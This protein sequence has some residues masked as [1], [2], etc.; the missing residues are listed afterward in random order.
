MLLLS[1]ISLTG[2]WSAKRGHFL[3]CAFDEN[4]VG[5]AALLLGHHGHPLH[6]GVEGVLLEQGQLQIGGGQPAQLQL[7]T[8]AILGVLHTVKGHCHE[9]FTPPPKQTINRCKI[10]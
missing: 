3:R 10:L 6:G 8:S 5:R 7:T 9:I 2:I 1:E 4:A